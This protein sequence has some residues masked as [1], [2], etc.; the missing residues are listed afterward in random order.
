MNASSPDSTPMA[1]WS[2]PTWATSTTL[3]GVMLD[4]VRCSTSV[5]LLAEREGQPPRDLWAEAYQSD[6][7]DIAD[8]GQVGVARLGEPEIVVNG[9]RLSLPAAH[10]FGVALCNLVEDI[11]AMAGLEVTR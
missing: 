4:H 9:L 3:N 7:I 6:R 11:E 5:P 8:D 2:A 1:R 10:N